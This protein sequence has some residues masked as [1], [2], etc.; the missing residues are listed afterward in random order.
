M[1][2]FWLV[3]YQTAANQVASGVRVLSK[4]VP[5]VAVVW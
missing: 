5:A 2:Y 4:I 1:P 3:T